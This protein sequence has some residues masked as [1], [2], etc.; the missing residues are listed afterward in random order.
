MRCHALVLVVQH[1]ADIGGADGVHQAVDPP[2][3]LVAGEDEGDFGVALDV[4][5]HG[6]GLL[7]GDQVGVVV[8][9]PLFSSK[10]PQQVSQQSLALLP[11]TIMACLQQ[12]LSQ[13]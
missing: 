7:H 11:S 13:L 3:L 4:G 2:A 12:W 5:Q 8:Q 6:F 9:Q 10:L 1:G